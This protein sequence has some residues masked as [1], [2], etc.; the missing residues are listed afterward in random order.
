MAINRTTFVAE[1]D[2]RARKEGKPYVSQVLN[3]YGQMG[4]IEDS[5]GNPIDPQK[6][7]FETVGDEI[8]FVG[9]PETCLESIR[10]YHD[11][12]GVTQ[13]NLRISMGNMPLELVER[14]VTLLGKHVLPHFRP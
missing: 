14:S 8:Y 12:A 4:L 3:F 6:D 7:L 10:H 5:Q 2:E 13:F 1:T 11:Q 9:S